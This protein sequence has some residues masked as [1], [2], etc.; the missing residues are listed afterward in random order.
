ML[1]YIMFLVVGALENFLVIKLLRN[2]SK[3][4]AALLRFTV[5]IFCTVYSQVVD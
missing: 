3:T 4:Y 2:F 5:I 1:T